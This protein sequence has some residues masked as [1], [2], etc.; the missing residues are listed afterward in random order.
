MRNRDTIS[1][2]IGPDAQGVVSGKDVHQQITT[3]VGG[4][5]TIIN[6]LV[7]M[8]EELSEMHGGMGVVH[9]ELSA[10]RNEIGVVRGES[11]LIKEDVRIAHVERAGM[12]ETVNGLKELVNT[13]REGIYPQWLRW[14]MVGMATIAILIAM[15]SWVSANSASD[16]NWMA[17]G[18]YAS[19]IVL[20][21]AHT[22]TIFLIYRLWNTLKNN[23]SEQVDRLVDERIHETVID[24]EKRIEDAKYQN[25]RNGDGPDGI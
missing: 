21:L 3:V 1:S 10:L 17:F 18:I 13:I 24:L 9:G 20:A 2:N 25:T 4:M 8:R 5:D 15:L 22:A 14:F 23:L 7:S 6:L 12:I 19:F 16:I 11:S